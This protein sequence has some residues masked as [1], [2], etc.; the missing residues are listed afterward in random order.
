MVMR[1]S[2]AVNKIRDLLGHDQVLLPI[3]RGHKRPSFEDWQNTSPDYMKEPEYLAQLAKG[4]IGVLLGHDQL[5][6]IDLDLDEAVEPF[7]NL[8]PKLHGTL[9]TKR[10]RGC[11]FWIRIKGKYPKPC[12]LQTQNGAR[13][14]EWRADGNQTVI[15][16]AAR[17][18]KK[19]ERKLI[20]YKIVVRSRPIEVAFDEINWPLGL[21]LPWVTPQGG[22]EEP[23]TAMTF[24]RL[25]KLYG[26]PYY[27][28]KKG[29]YAINQPFWAG[30]FAAENTVLWEPTERD[31]YAYN[32]E[33][34]IYEE[35]SADLIKRQLSERL[36]GASKE[37]NCFW[38]QTQRTNRCLN[39][40]TAQLRGIVE[41]RDA[42]AHGER[43]VH[44]NNGVFRF[45][46]GGELLPFSPDFISRNRSP[47]DFDADA[48][49]PRFLDELIY[50][51]LHPDDVVLVQKYFGQCLL[52]TNLIQRILILDGLSERGKT[53]LANV[54]QAVV[55]RVNCTQLRTELLAQRFETYR[56]V[57][58]TLLIGVDVVPDFLSTPGASYLKGLV[59]GDW[60]DGEKKNS[61]DSFQFQGDRGV[62]ITANSRLRVRLAGDI[63]AWR[64]RLLI[65]RYEGP[66]PKRK[67]PNFGEKLVREE[68]S[69]ILSWAIAGLAMLLR[70]IDETGDIVLSEQQL[71]IVDSLLA[72]SDSLRLFLQEKVELAED[73]DLSVSDIIERY[74]AYCPEKGW[75]PLPITEVQ[76]SLEGLML[77]AFHVSKSHCIKREGHS[78]R[79]FFGVRF[80]PDEP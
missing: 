14:G 4:N 24:D 78:V 47:I 20:P 33:I 25:K 6:T 1:G 37:I 36:L 34:G 13:W 28:N 5:V 17:D 75:M 67:I 29:P 62:I 79:G 45:E 52:G 11:N 49:C 43:R 71:G 41:H 18:R 42:F 31:F 51:A 21:V 15:H 46:N 3:P 59:G 53:Q 69:G 80:K 77:Q 39:D 35:M 73:W 65:A 72:E 40:I 56:F 10:A 44:L 76:R 38:L 19:G 50:P 8:N 63:A 54:V 12:I 64:R 16:G 55:G 32:P 58:K 2:A 68:G 27:E 70:D 48:E 23:S 30:L 7:L 22:K 9:R 66:K 74:A 60:F 26:E 57:K 61:V